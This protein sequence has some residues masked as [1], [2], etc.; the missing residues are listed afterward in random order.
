MIMYTALH[1]MS[2]AL[3][4]AFATV[5]NA[6]NPGVQ[7]GYTMS[8]L[9]Y[10]QNI[11]SQGLGSMGASTN[12]NDVLGNAAKLADQNY[13]SLIGFSSNYMPIRQPLQ[14]GN[15]AFV[16]RPYKNSSLRIFFSEEYKSSESIILMPA[17]DNELTAPKSLNSFD[18]IMA[19]G[20]AFKL[21]PRW[22]GAITAKYI[23]S[24]LV[25]G[26]WSAPPHGSAYDDATTISGDL[27]VVY[28]SQNQNHEGFRFGAVLANIG[29]QLNYLP[30]DHSKPRNNIS[31]LPMNFNIGLG[32]GFPRQKN[33]NQFTLA[34]DIGKEI[35]TQRANMSFGGQYLLHESSRMSTAF[36]L[37]GTVGGVIPGV[38]VAVTQK[39]GWF[40]FTGGYLFSIGNPQN[41]VGKNSLQFGT[42]MNW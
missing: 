23:V 9:N 29:P 32:Y 39:I 37:G 36:H 25:N 1:L 10:A 7:R 14:T 2:I 12:A 19:M 13:N 38:T 4:I 24:S 26:T 27:S 30:T 17:A 31:Q 15:I 22:S 34:G 41:F 35:L 18:M 21:A 42:S 40:N 16:A 3:L 5:A 11:E 33:G 20:T 28:T 8:Y 6:Q